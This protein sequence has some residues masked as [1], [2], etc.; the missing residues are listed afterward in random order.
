MILNHTL[1]INN[2][3][4][5]TWSVLQSCA[6]LRFLGIILA[7]SRNGNKIAPGATI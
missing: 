5:G 2:I 3:S 4:D 6:V 7:V 1:M